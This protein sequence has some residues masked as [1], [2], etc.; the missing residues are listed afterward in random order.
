MQD[1]TFG[2]FA[3]VLVDMDLSQ[4]LS[5]KT[6]N[7][8][9][10]FKSDK[11]VINKATI[12]VEPINVE[13]LSEKSRPVISKEKEVE[14][15][16]LTNKEHQITQPQQ[17]HNETVVLGHVLNPAQNENSKGKE[18]EVNDLTSKEHENT[19]TQ[20]FYKDTTVLSPVSP[21]QIFRNQ[22][23]QLENELNDKV[24]VVAEK[25]MSEAESSASFVGATQNHMGITSDF[26]ASPETRQTP[27]RVIKDMEFLKTSWANMAEEEEEAERDSV[28]AA[29]LL[30]QSDDGFQVILGAHEH[31]GRFS[32]ARLPMNT[33]YFHRLA[34]IKT[35]SKIIT[36]IQDGEHDSLLAEEVIPN[37]VTDEVN[38][39]LIMLP[40]HDEIKA[41]VFALNKDSAPGPNGFGAFF[42]QDYWILLTWML[43]M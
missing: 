4:P 29:D 32:P 30:Q 35:S 18:V 23:Q 27:D 15:Q 22:D 40:S 42:Y 19:K 6:W 25:I 10:E 13:D 12:N 31:R 34:K 28:A 41:A 11:E 8:E 38:A 1:C 3:R 43:S 2:Q 36:S 14:V 26:T 21:A 5:C 9:E 33:K 24:E 20:Q 39:I 16:E 17:L 7:K 37:M